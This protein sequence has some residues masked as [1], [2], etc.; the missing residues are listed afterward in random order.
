[1]KNL[2]FILGL[3][4]AGTLGA[5]NSG[6]K[7]IVSDKG[8]GEALIASTVTVGENGTTTDFDGN[9]LI[10]LAPGNYEIEF[11]YIGYESFIQSVTV[12]SGSYTELNVQLGFTTNLLETAVVTGSK[13]ERPLSESPVSI[14]VLSSELIS[15]QNAANVTA[16]IDKTPGLQMIDGQANIRGGSGFSYGAGSRVM[17]LVDDIPALQADAGR[18]NWGDIPVENISQIEIIKGASS[19]L[20]GSSAL[21]G[22]INVRSG[23]ATSEPQ[24]T[25]ALSHTIVGA[26]KDKEK[27]WWSQDYRDQWLDSIPST[28]AP[29]KTTAS[30]F[31]KRKIGKLDLVLHT[32]YDKEKSRFMSDLDSLHMDNQKLR[33]GMHTKYR[34]TDKIT[35]G[36]AGFITRNESESPF[37][38]RNEQVGA[39]RH[40]SGAFTQGKN[41]RWYLDPSFTMFDN[42]GN[43]HKF[44]GRVFYIENDNSNN[45]SNSSINYYGEYQFLRNF[46]NIGFSLTSGIAAQYAESDSPLFGGFLLES[47]NV[48]LYV[49]GEQRIGDRLILT[50]GGRLEQ[51]Y[52]T[53]PPVSPFPGDTTVYDASSQS[54]AALIGRFGLNYEAAEYTFLRASIGQGYRYPSIAERFIIT[55]FGGFNIFPNPDLTSEKGW[56][57]EIGIKQGFQLGLFKGY[58]DVAIFYS[59]YTNMM[60]WSFNETLG[61]IGLQS[62]NIGDIAIPGFEFNIVGQFNISKVPINVLAGYTYINPTYQNFED[63]K[64]LPRFEWVYPEGSNVPQ[65]I[66]KDVQNVLKYRSKHNIKGDVEASYKNLKLGFT[67][68]YVS[69]Q[70]NIDEILNNLGNIAQ[71]RDLSDNDGW[72]TLDMRLSAEFDAF[73]EKK[74]SGVKVS[75]VIKNILNEEYSQRNGLL[76]NPRNFGLRA[77]ITF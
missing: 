32:L 12:N 29:F 77:D 27:M 66:S 1:M 51:N 2:L 30:I 68:A 34:I 19:V 24:T 53:N 35:V 57:S 61:G 49:Q 7:G 22:I 38:W 60:E 76:E 54:E 63:I 59:E 8:S 44:V 36:L 5:Q 37:L 45:Q 26:P 3:F 43:K 9:Y 14:A 67:Y 25:V 11:S 52:A 28:H 70:E 4:L 55:E 41:F 23:Y 13:Y 75:L 10:N 31:H 20:Y 21:N 39:Y 65:Q 50:G 18:P 40:L 48:G 72:M 74:K 58:A 56:S 69:H 42:F 46:E 16:V 62:Q 6:V 64:G 47:G 17:L 15:S 71:Y 33:L 73:N